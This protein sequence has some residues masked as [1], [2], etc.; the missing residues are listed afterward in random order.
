MCV[1]LI[2]FKVVRS[3]QRASQHAP[4]FGRFYIEVQSDSEDEDDAGP[5]Q[6]YEDLFFYP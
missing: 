3:W 4:P 6:G 1:L 2:W 5:L